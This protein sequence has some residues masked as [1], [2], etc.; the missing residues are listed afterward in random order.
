MFLAFAVVALVAPAICQGCGKRPFQSTR[1]VNGDDAAPHSWPWQV[2]LRKDGYHICGGS[3]IKPNWVVT[4]AHCV[5]KNP[6]PLAYTVVVGV[7][8]RLGITSVEKV[9]RVKTLHKHSG[10]TMD[11]LKHDIAVLEL[12]G[13]VTVSDKVSTVCL[14][15]DA[16]KPGTKCYITGW[17]LLSGGGAQANVLQQGE[18]PVVSHE[19]CAKKY[20]RYDSEAHLCAGKG[21]ES[22]S[23]GCQGDSGGPLVCE[24]YGTWYLHGAV[25]FGKRGCPTT[26]YTVFTRITTYIPW[27]NNKIGGGSSTAPVPEKPSSPPTP[28][29]P[30]PSKAKPGC[31]DTKDYCAANKY[32]CNKMPSF[33][34]DC[35]K[36]CNVC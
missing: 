10:F 7:H 17:G 27:I 26:A 3:L 32:F 15:T 24:K 18:L 13:S 20:T 6:N 9:F 5:Y 36:T 25:S 21:L 31:K 4:A 8:K 11:N 29:V 2:S 22:G 14:P 30:S 34:K 1:V 19:D 35:P 28:P 16:P 33:R 23:G 12:R